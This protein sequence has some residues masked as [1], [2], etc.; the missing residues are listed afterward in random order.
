Q[1]VGLTAIV[2]VLVAALGLPISFWAGFVHERRWGFSTQDRS[3]FAADRAKGF[4]LG[5]LLTEV[6]LVGLVGTG[7]L[8][9][10][11]WPLVACSIGALLVLALGLLA[12]LL[13][14]PLF[15]RF[16]PLRDAELASD[17]QRLAE[18]AHLAVKEVLV[19]DASRRT[20]KTNAYVSGLGPTRRLVL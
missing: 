14:E 5:L 17:L 20:R 4:A 15:N 9:P 18:R 12:P 7:R 11:L 2:L 16:R 1:V 13:V 19:A 3:A 6:A 8:L 10:R